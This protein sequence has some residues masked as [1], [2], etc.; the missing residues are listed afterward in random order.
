AV[1]LRA[2]EKRFVH[3]KWFEFVFENDRIL[4]TG[5]IN[6]TSKALTTTDNVEVGILRR[7]PP[8]HPALDCVPAD[9]PRF[10]ASH[11]LPS[12]LGQHEIVFASFDRTEPDPPS[13]TAPHAQAC[14]RPLAGPSRAGRWRVHIIGGSRR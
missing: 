8:I 5:S 3:A 10:Q 4:L 11:R 13:R 9:T 12:G 7:L 2:P 1:R 14:R 6:A